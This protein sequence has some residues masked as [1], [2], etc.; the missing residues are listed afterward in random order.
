MPA[1]WF[2][3]TCLSARDPTW[4]TN[5]SGAFGGLLAKLE[6]KNSSAFRLPQEIREYFEGVQTGADGEYEEAIVVPKPTRK[7]K[8]EEEAVPDF[9]R[10]RDREDQPVLCHHCQQATA[11]DR[12]IIPCSV[13]GV[14]WH[15]DCLDPPL[16]RA[17]PLRTWKC[18]LH[19]DE[20]VNK[21]PGYLGPA[22]K[23][24]KIKD[25]KVVDPIFPRGNLNNGYIE[26]IDDLSEDESGLRHSESFGRI[27]RLR[28]SAIEKDF[29]YK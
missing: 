15:L 1:E 5:T 27:F 23:Y 11:E 6:A 16:S 7:R 8:A 20:L 26:V 25:E 2:C 4:G 21:V 18:P 17:P 14:F 24:R 9:H 28:A 29:F 22:H 13:C 12:V 10:V 3:N 19:V